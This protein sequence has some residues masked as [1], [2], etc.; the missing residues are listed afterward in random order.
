MHLRILLPV[1][2]GLAA[3]ATADRL[4]VLSEPRSIA[5]ND[6]DCGDPKGCPSLNGISLDAWGD[7]L[8][9]S[10]TGVSFRLARLGDSIA[11]VD[12]LASDSI[13]S[14]MPRTFPVGDGT[15]LQVSHSWLLSLDWNASKA[16]TVQRDVGLGYARSEG[17]LFKGADGD[18]LHGFLCSQNA[19]YV[20]KRVGRNNWSVADYDMLDGEIRQHCALNPSTRRAIRFIYSPK[21]DSSKVHTGDALQI[22][23]TPV[24]STVNIRPTTVFAGE[25]D[26]W[27][28]YDDSTGTAM[29]RYG[30]E[31]RAMR[32]TILKPTELAE[33][34]D[35]YIHP[36]R[37][38]S[39]IVFG[40]DSTLVLA[41]WVGARFQIVQ[42]IQLDASIT[43]AMALGDSTLW[44]RTG[45]R[46]L[47]FRFRWEDRPSS[48]TTP[49]TRMTISSLLV[50]QQDAG[51]VITWNGPEATPLQILGIDGSTIF[52]SRM[53]PGETRSIRLPSHGGLHAIR[54]SGEAKMIMIK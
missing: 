21:K 5:I 40:G 27:L 26:G 36:I 25:D 39:L 8:I 20:V 18:T 50:R 32:D 24:V 41:K 4:P 31:V 47:S 44:V 35:K 52:Q 7:T 6:R 49:R 38:D 19:A 30:Y 42:S 1:L 28:A 14:E 23:K 9:S 15:H 2:A 53:T 43:Y 16:R 29:I 46:I 10:R 22:F 45:S 54:T 12:S 48:G 37:K 3:S 33:L 51:L 34:D 17:D 11:F 13:R